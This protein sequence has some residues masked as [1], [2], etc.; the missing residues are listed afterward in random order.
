VSNV[1][2]PLLR[3]A[4]EWAEGEAAKPPTQSEWHQGGWR[5]KPHAHAM[6]LA[7]EECTGEYGV[8]VRRWNAVTEQLT[9]EC[10]A[11][12]CIAGYITMV[13]HHMEFDD[14]W[15]RD[16]EH[17]STVASRLLG[18]EPPRCRSRPEKGHL[19][20]ASNSIRD[21][22]RIAGKLAGERL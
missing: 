1:N 2:V 10:G 17:V 20:C 18:I 21:L 9:P 6:L 3:K 8:N 14:S 15:H 7:E 13:V 19:F 4:L 5:C 22:R 12:Y 16:N 11:S